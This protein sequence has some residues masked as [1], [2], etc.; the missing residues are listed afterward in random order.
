[1]A[2]GFHHSRLVDR[3]K[4]Q[5]YMYELMSL[6]TSI[7]VVAPVG[8][9]TRYGGPYLA[10]SLFFKAFFYLTK[11]SPGDASGGGHLYYLLF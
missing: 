11:T 6:A 7:D 1:M 9:D 10:F 8:P 4:S 5:P 3:C 2:C